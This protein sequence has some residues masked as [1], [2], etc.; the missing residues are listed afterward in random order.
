[1]EGGRPSVSGTVTIVFALIVLAAGL[2]CAKLVAGDEPQL[3]PRFGPYFGMNRVN[4]AWVPPTAQQQILDAMTDHGIDLVRLS[5]T[6]PFDA[7]IGALRAAHRNGMHILL[8]IPLSNE[9]FYPSNAGKRSGHGRIWDI[10]RLSDIDPAA[11][12]LAFREAMQRIDALG[13]T[14]LAVQPGNELNLGGYNGD[15]HVYARDN[16][17]TARTRAELTN[18]SAFERGIEKYVAILQIVREEIE[19]SSA[20]RQAKIIS[21]GI[22]DMGGA[23][24]DE[25][26]IERLDAGEFV[27][28][29]RA[30]DIEKHIDAYGVHV[31]PSQEWSAD[32]RRRHVS[33]ILSVCK[34]PPHGKPCWITEWGIANVSDRCPLPDGDREGVIREIRDLFKSLIDQERLSLAFYFDW[35]SDTPY[36]VWRCATLTPAGIAAIS[37]TSGSVGAEAD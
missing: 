6:P 21:A 17:R 15:L 2:F 8:E 16:M 7:S 5:L 31:Y 29:L 37:P 35:D 25:R 11:F 26:G 14:L 18:R 36:S 34:A 33:A 28:I 12:R 19:D 1:M 30:A 22:S 32:A 24:A 13:I 4:L 3:R 20:S 23:A 10:H 9:D 27:A